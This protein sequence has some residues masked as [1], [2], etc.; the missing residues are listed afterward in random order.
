MALIVALVFTGCGGV[1]ITEVSIPQSETIAVGETVDLVAS[2][3]A[4]N[5]D[6]EAEKI[7]QAVSELSQTWTSSDEKVATVSPTGV[8]T[9]IA[10]GK[11][12]ITLSVMDG[13]LSA[14]TDVTVTVPLESIEVEDIE[15]NTLDNTATVSYKL[16]PE[17]STLD[18]DTEITLS[19]E[20]LAELNGDK[21]TVLK[22]GTCDVIV[23]NGDITGKATLNIIQAPEKL[24]LD[25]VYLTA[26]YSGSISAKT[27]V[28]AEVGTQFTYTIADTSVATVSGSTVKGLKAGNT[29]ITVKNELG[30]TTTAKVVVQPKPQPVVVQSS[31][32]SSQKTGKTGGTGSYSGG[33]GGSS[34]S[35]PRTCTCSCARTCTRARTCTCTCPACH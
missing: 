1:N 9:G 13:T 29:T 34:G 21:L 22:A 11:A 18:A 28:N 35:N 30:Q 4:E 15:L 6:I 27:G 10:G 23:T 25:D 3:G 20:T 33:S 26:G 32:D 24:T 19:D 7:A 31:T 8:V 2:F 14:S 12:T 17:N 16:F 5:P